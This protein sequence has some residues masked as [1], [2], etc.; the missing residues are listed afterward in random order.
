M[1]PP[2]VACLSAKKN[3]ASRSRCDTNP[4]CKAMPQPCP[5]TCISLRA[6]IHT[7]A[8]GRMPPFSSSRLS[9]TSSSLLP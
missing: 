5:P 9:A 6:Q 1:Q 4:S 8:P 2:A 7:P 3:V